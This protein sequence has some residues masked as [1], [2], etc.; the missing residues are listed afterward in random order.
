MVAQSG[1]CPGVQAGARNVCPS[2]PCPLSVRW[3]R[4]RLLSSSVADDPL[5]LL[6]MGVSGVEGSCFTDRRKRN[7]AGKLICHGLASSIP[8]DPAVYPMSR[9]PNSPFQMQWGLL[10]LGIGSIL[11]ILITM[12]LAHWFDRT[13]HKDSDDDD[14]DEGEKVPDPIQIIADIVMLPKAGRAASQRDQ[15]FS[16]PAPAPATV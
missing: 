15:R 10:L 12:F 11:G 8:P 2:I 5:A 4:R 9:Y 1:Q 16:V 6:T 7:P 3:R 13:G 14:G